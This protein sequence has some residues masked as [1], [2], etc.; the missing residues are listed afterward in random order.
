M[1]ENV[2]FAA[3]AEL[4]KPQNFFE[5]TLKRFI[6]SGKVITIMNCFGNCANY[7]KIEEIKTETKVESTKQN[8]VVSRLTNKHYTPYYYRRK[9]KNQGMMKNM[10]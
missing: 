1:N 6:G 7:Y 5:I 4:P 8:L 9:T 2:V 3:T 10:F